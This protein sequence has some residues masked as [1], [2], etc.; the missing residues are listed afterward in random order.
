MPSPESS[1]G[2]REGLALPPIEGGDARHQVG[3]VGGQVGETSILS[4]AGLIVAGEAG[5]LLAGY[6]GAYGTHLLQWDVVTPSLSFG[7]GG[8]I[9]LAAA[10]L[11]SVGPGLRPIE[12]VLP[13]Q[14]VYA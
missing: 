13:L 2:E 7:R 14:D 5:E 6:E 12:S 11:G 9:S 4:R 10:G 8:L 3:G 1:H